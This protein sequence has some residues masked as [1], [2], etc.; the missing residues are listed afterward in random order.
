M[1]KK[2]LIVL[3]LVNCVV[4]LMLV[5]SYSKHGSFVPLYIGFLPL[6]L[7]NY[8]FF[9]EFI[10]PKPNSWTNSLPA[11]PTSRLRFL[12]LLIM[13]IGFCLGLPA[14]IQF[15]GSLGWSPV[16]SLG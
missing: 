6:L 7:S 5:V 14:L 1:F 11:R 8:I 3:V 15:D 13:P 4:V 10:A 9:R 2:S 12:P 16:V